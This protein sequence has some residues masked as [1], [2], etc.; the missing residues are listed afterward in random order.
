MCKPP[1]LFIFYYSVCGFHSV[2]TGSLQKQCMSEVDIRKVVA[3]AAAT[4]KWV[5][6]CRRCLGS[7]FEHRASQYSQVDTTS[8][9]CS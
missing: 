7:I 9:E 8:R 4:F 1:T 5:V 2:I 3:N 6:C